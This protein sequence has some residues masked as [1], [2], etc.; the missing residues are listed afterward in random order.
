[1]NVRVR[2]YKLITASWW[3]FFLMT[4]EE[5]KKELRNR[6]LRERLDLVADRVAELSREI[7]GRFL[8]TKV[9]K[10]CQSVG[11]YSAIRN[12]VDTGQIYAAARE[13]GLPVYFPRVEQGIHFYQVESPD[14]LQ[15]GAWGILE[16]KESCPPLEESLPLDLIVMPGVVFD[17][18]GY[19]LG[20]GRG[21]YDSL[22][23][24]YR[25]KSVGLAYDFQVVDN[26]LVD[27]WDRRLEGLVTEK[28]LLLFDS[29]NAS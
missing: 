4:I 7:Q 1:M 17:E 8:E 20:Y 24:N 16:P 11:L 22:L 18:R 27:E 6:V 19:R 3:G 13:R 23:K 12:E 10:A 2:D 29:P 5:Q 28:R 14:E 21:F 15:K 26:L 25:G 9:W